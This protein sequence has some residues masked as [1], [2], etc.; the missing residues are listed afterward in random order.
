MLYL[1]LIIANTIMIYRK[2]NLYKII[3]RLKTD[4]GIAK[5]NKNF[6]F[7]SMPR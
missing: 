3:F 4:H 7:Y 1:D 2:Y 5:I 6:L